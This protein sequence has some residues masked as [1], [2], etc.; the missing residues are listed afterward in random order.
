MPFETHNLIEMIT[1]IRDFFYRYFV[2]EG[3]NIVNTLVYGLVLGVLSLFLVIPLIKRLRIKIGK[4]FLIGISTFIFYGATTRE[5]VDKQLGIY[6]NAGTYPQ[7]FY[8]VSPTIHV[9][10]FVL[11]VLVLLLGLA[12]QEYAKRYNKKI[13]YHVTMFF[14]GSL[15]CVYNLV[16][17]IQNI[18]ALEPLFYVLFSFCISVVFLY[19]LIRYLKLNFL[20]D[21]RVAIIRKGE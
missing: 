5:L 1:I 11:T 10:M 14:V 7:N 2:Y 18:T 13:G 15:L 12:I 19:I 3:Y 21:N 16:L 20:R 9:T 8:L 6:A 17:I 4:D